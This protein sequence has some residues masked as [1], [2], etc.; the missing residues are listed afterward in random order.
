MVG[1]RGPVPVPV[2][3]NGTDL[4]L[5]ILERLEN[6]DPLHTEDAYPEVP[7]AQLKAALDRLASRAML[8]YDTNDAERVVLTAEGQQIADEG[9]HE[10]KVW[11]AVKAA[12]KLGVKDPSL[13]TPN[14]KVGLG[15]AMKLKW[16]K[17]DGDALV[18]LQESVRDQTREVLQFAAQAGSFPDAKQQ[19][20]FQK[21]KL[22]TTKKVITYSV[23]KGPRW[24]KEI[25]VEV[26]DLTAEMIEDG[27]WKTATFKPYNFKAL[28]ANQNAGTLHPL[29]KVREEFRK[30]FFNWDF[31][32]MP[33]ARFVDTGFWNFDALFV[34]QQHPARDLQDTFYVSD[35]AESGLPGP[36]PIA[37]AA[38]NKMEA[39]SRL[40]A[41]GTSEEAK[42]LD[43]KKYSED[44]RAV[45]Q[46][47]KFGSI[48]YRAPYAESE[49]TRL[50]LRTHTTAVSTYCL[51]RLAANPRPARYFSID[52]VFRNETVDATHLAEFH[53]IEGVI[54][55]YG[56]TLGGLQ[57]FL[58]KFF[59]Q[60]GITNL[61][62]KPAYNPY[63]E[64]SMEVFGF[65]RGLNK[66]VEIG[67]SGMFRPE[68]LLPMGL[69]EDLRV[70]GFG[71]SLER[72][73]MIKYGVSNIRELLG[74]KVDLGFI[75]SNP[76][77][78]LD[79]D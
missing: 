52:R 14:A 24:A 44:V 48:G 16:V 62:F 22:V 67:N 76:A 35:P 72:P 17:K 21:R 13:A 50:V 10:Y 11:E 27:S 74:H 51:H 70:Y 61:R 47:G 45:H 15:N 73:T 54:A 23:R 19:K 8:E 1:T 60:L 33:T 36:D 77:V 3:A 28:G 9:S 38:L 39:D 55:D 34:P 42:P 20:E 30:I 75:E 7:Q 71:L 56:L 37:D 18:S 4:T 53:Q 46:E 25:P 63:T 57:A 5:D 41:T 40:F 79:K 59:E 78:R 49:T 12:G 66:W 32:E 26:T 2:Q 64:P 68:M 29:N 43:Y 69:P 31:I 58:G 65:H 6:T